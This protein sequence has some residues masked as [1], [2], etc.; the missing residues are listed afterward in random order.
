MRHL[1][2]LHGAIGCMIQLQPLAELLS[3]DYIVHTLDFTGHGSKARMTDV[4]SMPVFANDVLNYMRQNE[5]AI[6]DIFGYSMGGYVALYLARHYPDRISSV[7][8]LATKFHWDGATAEKEIQML[9]AEKIEAKLPVFAE[10][11]RLRHQP[12]DWKDVLAGTAEMMRRLGADTTMKS[13]DYVGVQAPCLI[14]LGD[15]DKMVSLD[16]T[17]AVYEAL[18]IAQLGILPGTSHPIEQMDI[19]LLEYMIKRFIK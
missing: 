4:Y 13:H 9:N 16:E 17:V 11:L 14:L 7:V 10:M 3:K 6:A 5:L 12:G 1:I 2:L 19:T 15:R 8:T 18:P